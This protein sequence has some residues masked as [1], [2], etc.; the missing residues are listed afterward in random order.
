MYFSFEACFAGL[1]PELA[2]EPAEWIGQQERSHLL[3]HFVQ[4]GIHAGNAAKSSLD[5]DGQCLQDR[6]TTIPIDKSEEENLPVP[7]VVNLIQDKS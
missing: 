1:V 5:V 7:G 4:I 3:V 6:G 2:L